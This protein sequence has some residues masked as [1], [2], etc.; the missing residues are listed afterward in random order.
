ML[1][2]AIIFLNS[3]IIFSQ[4]KKTILMDLN[5]KIDSLKLVEANLKDSLFKLNNQFSLAE[6][7]NENLIVEKEAQFNTVKQ[8]RAEIEGYK[9]VDKTI[10]LKFKEL[11]LKLKNEIDNFSINQEIIELDRKLQ[12]KKEIFSQNGFDFYDEKDKSWGMNFKIYELY[13][14]SDS[15]LFKTVIN[16]Y[17]SGGGNLGSHLTTL[18]FDYFGNTIYSEHNVFVSRDW[19]DDN[20][21]SISNHDI[22]EFYFSSNNKLIHQSHFHQIYVTCDL[23]PEEE[24]I[25]ESAYKPILEIYSDI[26]QKDKLYSDRAIVLKHLNQLIIK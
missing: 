3:L 18:Y 16:E 6:K 17:G 7:T 20:L 22:Y 13:F 15:L 25:N 2:C 12:F 19:T 5:L 14:D 10:N 9:S 1:F 8:L 11:S 24:S 23:K 4:S 21:N 26:L